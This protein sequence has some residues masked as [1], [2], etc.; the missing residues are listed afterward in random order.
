MH[1]RSERGSRVNMD[2]HAVPVFLLYFL[3]GG[4]DQNIIHVKLFEIL[5]PVVDPVLVL[6]LGCG[7]GTLTDIHEIAEF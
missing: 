7:D 6:C 2:D 3:P 1:A 4:N 5:F